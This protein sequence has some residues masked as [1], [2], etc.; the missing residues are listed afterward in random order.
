LLAGVNW[1]A[2]GQQIAHGN[3]SNHDPAGVV[4][5]YSLLN[6]DLHYQMG[7]QLLLSANLNN[8]LNKQYATYGLSGATSLY[9]LVTQQFVTPAAPRSLWLNL[10]YR[11]GGAKSGQHKD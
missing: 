11:F 2:A 4:P 9:T 1:V 8:A 10:T 3:E 5:G 6:L 7:D